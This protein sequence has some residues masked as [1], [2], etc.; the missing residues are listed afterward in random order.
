MTPNT[1]TSEDM[2][3]KTTRPHSSLENNIDDKNETTYT[4]NV[5][6]RRMSATEDGDKVLESAWDS[7]EKEKDGK[8]PLQ[9]VQN[10]ISKIED[11]K[12]LPATISRPFTPPTT[13]HP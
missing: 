10:I 5:E 2:A 7:P 11:P 4:K 1:P 3:I 9:M 8:T 6:I 13:S 12:P